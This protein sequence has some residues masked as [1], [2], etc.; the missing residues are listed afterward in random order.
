MI[1]NCIALSK[2]V[3][4]ANPSSW[5]AEPHSQVDDMPS[6]AWAPNSVIKYSRAKC[7]T[8]RQESEFK[9]LLELDSHR[10]REYESRWQRRKDFS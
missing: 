2:G 1:M 8:N 7:T 6:Y 4:N 10:Q 5:F 3:E 9:H